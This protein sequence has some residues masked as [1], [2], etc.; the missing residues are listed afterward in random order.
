MQSND[1]ECSECSLFR[2]LILQWNKPQIVKVCVATLI[3]SVSGGRRLGVSVMC[4]S[5]G[6][7]NVI[8]IAS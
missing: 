1:H 3:Y 7:I 4:K 2:P 8:A 6:S 5:V